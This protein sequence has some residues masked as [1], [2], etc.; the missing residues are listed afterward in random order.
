MNTK[1]LS[2]V[3]AVSV[4]AVATVALSCAGALTAHAA[5]APPLYPGSFD[6]A[7]IKVLDPGRESSLA[8]IE[9]GI[10]R[11]SSNV[12]AADLSLGLLCDGIPYPIQTAHDGS[13]L[14]FKA[15][16]PLGL[17]GHSCDLT[18]FPKNGQRV[19]FTIPK[20]DGDRGAEVSLVNGT[21]VSISRSG[22]L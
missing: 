14:S 10:A 5:V 2:R 4:V 6:L 13:S 22:G 17:I 12:T 11:V 1:L 18:S 15:T 8:I 19:Y 7:T 16:L 3:R 21:L 9:G 20:G